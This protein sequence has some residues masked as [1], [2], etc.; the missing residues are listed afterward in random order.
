MGKGKAECELKQSTRDTL[1]RRG[2]LK[3][4]PLLAVT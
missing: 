3:L 1:N 2:I 4:G